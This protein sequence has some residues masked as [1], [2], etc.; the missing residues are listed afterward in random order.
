VK[1]L[2]LIPPDPENL[3]SVFRGPNKGAHLYLNEAYAI[4]ITSSTIPS[5]RLR[6]CSIRIRNRLVEANVYPT[7]TRDVLPANG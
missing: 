7:A 6:H 5:G 1:H 3:I 4:T 2:Q